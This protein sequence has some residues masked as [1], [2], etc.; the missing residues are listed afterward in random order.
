MPA[1]VDGHAY[2]TGRYST[3]CTVI[4]FDSVKQA[5]GTQHVTTSKYAYV[6]GGPLVF[7]VSDQSMSQTHQATPDRDKKGA[8]ARYL[9]YFGYDTNLLFSPNTLSSYWQRAQTGE[10]SV[11]YQQVESLA[12]VDWTLTGPIKIVGKTASEAAASPS[13]DIG[14][15]DGSAVGAATVGATLWV[16]VDIDGVLL[17]VQSILDPTEWPNSVDQANGAPVI[18]SDLY[19]FTCHK[20]ASMT[21]TGMPTL[22]EA[23]PDINQPNTNTGYW[24]IQDFNVF[25]TNGDAMPSLWVQERFVPGPF[26]KWGSAFNEDPHKLYSTNTA[27]WP[28]FRTNWSEGTLWI[29]SAPAA[30]NVGDPWPGTFGHDNLIIH[31]DTGAGHLAWPIGSGNPAFYDATHNYFAATYDADKNGTTGIQIGSYHLQMW[32]DT[33]VHSKN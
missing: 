24:A 23:Y 14:A 22:V 18:D 28:G 21:A 1:T 20:P 10:V 4:Y 16:T 27:N 26:T 5:T 31:L 33:L 3:G 15:T 19:T 32:T 2:M 17:S 30:T 12:S 13:I 9:Q 7:S 11:Q 29:T 6:L 8:G 25:D